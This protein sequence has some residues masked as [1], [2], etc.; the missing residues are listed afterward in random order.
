MLGADFRVDTK[1]NVAA[2]LALLAD[3]YRAAVSA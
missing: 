1:S 2:Q 3:R